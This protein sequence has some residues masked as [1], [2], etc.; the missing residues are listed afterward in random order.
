MIQKE[1]PEAVN[2][3]GARQVGGRGAGAWKSLLDSDSPLQ[4]GEP[5]AAQIINPISRRVLDSLVRQ[6]GDATGRK[7][8]VRMVKESGANLSVDDI[9]ELARAH[10]GSAGLDERCD[11]LGAL[12]DNVE[13]RPD[14][15]EVAVIVADGVRNSLNSF[16]QLKTLA[17]DNA[18]NVC[19]AAIV[20]EMPMMWNDLLKN[21]KSTHSTAENFG[22]NFDSTN[23]KLQ[24][25]YLE[26]WRSCIKASLKNG[27]PF[28]IV[29]YAAEQEGGK[30]AIGCLWAA[31]EFG[32]SEKELLV[33]RIDQV[34][35]DRGALHISKKEIERLSEVPSGM[36]TGYL[37]SCIGNAFA[38]LLK[39]GESK[40]HE[41]AMEIL[42]IVMG[43]RR[44]RFVKSALESSAI[45]I[46][47]GISA[48]CSM[49]PE[50]QSEELWAIARI[51]FAAMAKSGNREWVKAAKDALDII[52]AERKEEFRLAAGWKA[53]KEKHAEEGAD[54]NGAA[55]GSAAKKRGWSLFR[56]FD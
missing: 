3:E 21:M 20:L 46:G 11:L 14:T 12:L 41:R 6:S 23:I 37:W 32:G 25:E 22:K 38:M 54:G 31:R 34:L 53:G 15:K 2:G 36:Q 9:G 28:E 16:F 52:P 42:P 7:E 4:K 35:G 8:I 10:A 1:K 49:E 39:S 51:E 30:Y 18:T 40:D 43:E 24:K 29:L 47:E 27:A 26:S 44:A 17:Y 50:H 48:L 55:E 45:P 56:L 13:A 33:K 5:K 19:R